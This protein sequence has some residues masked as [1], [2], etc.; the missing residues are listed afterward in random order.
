MVRVMVAIDPDKSSERAFHEAMKTYKDDEDD[1]LFLVAIT[2][3]WDYLN[4]EKNALKIELYK[5][6]SWCEANET[7]C[8]VIQTEASDVSTAYI[9]MIKK[10]RIEDFYVGAS[11]F[12]NCVDP[13]NHIFNAFSAVKRL[14]WGTVAQNVSKA[15]PAGQSTCRVHV[16]I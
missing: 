2:S 3:S 14:F 4:E 16:V 5:Y 12:V 9:E 8:R 13:D 7:L 1:K 15:F 10:K 11:A 6:E